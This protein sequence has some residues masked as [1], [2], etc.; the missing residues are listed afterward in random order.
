MKSRRAVAGIDIGG[1]KKGNHLVILRGTKI[2][3][4]IRRKTPEFMLQACV[5]FDV[6]AV[7]IDAPCQWRVGETGRLAERALA[8]QR[9]SLFATPTREQA[10]ASQSGF[11]GWMFNGERIYQTFAPRFPLYASL[12]GHAGPVCFETFPHAITCAL[13]KHEAA[14]AKHKHSQRRRV[15]E[16]AGID[17]ASL[18]SIDEVD[19]ALCA[20]SANFLLQGKVVAHGDALGGFIVVPVSDG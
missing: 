9:I 19:A 10:L 6:A 12:A 2:A 14:S 18:R 7:G 11:Y 8:Q 1:D 3:C 20:L 15:L 5:E 17:A 16:E 13:L 4:S